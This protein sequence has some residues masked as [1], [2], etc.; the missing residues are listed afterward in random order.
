MLA[1]FPMYTFPHNAAA[2]DRLWALIRDGLR[3]RGLAAPDALDTTTS[4]MDGW[5]DPAL[6][7]SQICSLPHRALFTGKVTLIA[8]CDYGAPGDAPGFYHSVFV[9]RKD[10]PAQD[11]VAAARYPMAINEPLSCSGWGAPVQTA[12]AQGLTLNPAMRTGSHAAS[13]RAVVAGQADLAAIDCIS[14]RN[15]QIALPEMAAVR[16]IG[17]THATPGMTFVTRAG[18]DPAPYRAAISAAITALDPKDQAILGLRGIVV[19]P[20]IH[21]DF[22]LPPQPWADA[23]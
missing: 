6:C 22:P 23:A 11:I 9:V 1:A 21:Y 3:G 12:R 4:H 7:L 19:L 10:D 17:R 20:E 16:V 8:A 15:L 14:F 2:H 5:A 13:V 18:Q